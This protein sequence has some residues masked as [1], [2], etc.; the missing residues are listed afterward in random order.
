MEDVKDSKEDPFKYLTGFG[1]EHES[2]A[3]PG[4]LPKGQ[5]NPQRC[6]HDLFAEQLS[7]TSFTTPRV[8]NQRSW[9]YRIKPTC[10]HKP[11]KLSKQNPR[12][13]SEFG[14]AIVNPNQIRWK[15]F[16]LPADGQRVNFVEGLST[17]AGSGGPELKS[18]LAIHVY[19]ANQSM[20]KENKAFVNSDGDFLIVPQLG[21]IT[22]R[23]EF[24]Y[25]HVPPNSIAVVQRGV[26]FQVNFTEPVV[27]GYVLEVFNNHF[28]LPDLGPI[29]ANGLANP[30]DFKYPVASYEDKKETHTIQQKFLGQL[31]EAEHPSSPFDVVA[32]FGNYAPYKYNL[33]DFVPA[34]AVRVDHMDPS[35]F[36]VLTCP[37]SEPG[38]AVADFVIFPPRWAVQEHTFRPPYYHRNC[39]SEFMGNIIGRYEA[40]PDGFMPGGGSLHSIMIGHGPDA[41]TFN[42]LST[43]ELKA[44]RMPDDSMSF[45]F[46]STYVFKLTEWA[47]SIQLK[48]ENYYK[49]WEGLGSKFVDPAKKD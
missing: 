10:A 17:V 45:M 16:P 43:D 2:E 30:R 42:K 6:A 19:A 15:P 4:T 22:L 3:I 1:G 29:G 13:Q 26:T 25:L 46:E 24:G 32:W 48:D 20:D 5:I 38:V 7:G 34:G 40:K 11:F 21:A 23:T 33:A 27:R 18:G 35:I 39:M 12:L 28:R 14:K 8:F 41:A 47:D 9:L 36:T 49:C 37:S 31:F 44:V